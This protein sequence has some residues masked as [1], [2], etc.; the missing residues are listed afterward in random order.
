MEF[1]ALAP[2]EPLPIDPPIQM[3][4]VQLGF[5]EAFIPLVDPNMHLTKAHSGPSL[6]TIRTWA[7]FFNSMDQTLPTVAISTQWMNFF[8]LL[9]MKQSSFD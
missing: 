3:D 8:T 4:N 2:N 6:D 9:M 1:D 7:K 5:V